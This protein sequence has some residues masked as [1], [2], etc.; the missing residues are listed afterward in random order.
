MELEFGFLELRSFRSA[1]VNFFPL[2]RSLVSLTGLDSFK[3]D[4]F[5][6][7]PLDWSSFFIALLFQL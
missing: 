2:R 3:G 7:S 1:L 6:L 5:S 4:Q